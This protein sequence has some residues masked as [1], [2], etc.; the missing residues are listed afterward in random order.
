MLLRAFVLAVLLLV[1][2]IPQGAALAAPRGT[3]PLPV[4]AAHAPLLIEGD[5]ALTAA[6]GVTGGSGTPSDP[7]EISGWA[8]NA[9]SATG[10]DVRNTTDPL[11]IRG[12][13]V[14]GA[15]A[16]W[17]HAGI[18]LANVS[19]VDLEN[20]TVRDSGGLLAITSRLVLVEYFHGWDILVPVLGS[21]AATLAVNHVVNRSFWR[22]RKRRVGKTWPGPE[23]P[24]EGGAA[25]PPE[26]PGNPEEPQ[27]PESR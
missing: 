7:Y 4:A 20:V 14:T 22:R 3:P 10:V 26:V 9:S 18:L 5:A 21:V 13:Q 16:P 2:V 19:H 11:V 1:L 17:T 25:V 23:T 8:I 12:L 15:G 27:G 24:K 6:N